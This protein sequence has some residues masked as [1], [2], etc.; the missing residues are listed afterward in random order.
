MAIDWKVKFTKNKNTTINELEKSV[1]HYSAVFQRFDDTEPDVI[2]NTVYIG[3]AIL[4]TPEQKIALW[5]L[6]YKQYQKQPV[7]DS[8]IGDLES[9]GKIALVAKEK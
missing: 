4:E 6:V 5:N 9:A 8:T 1:T 2:L 3:D 7:S